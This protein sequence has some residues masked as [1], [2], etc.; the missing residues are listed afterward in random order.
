MRIH[1]QLDDS[2]ARLPLTIRSADSVWDRAADLRSAPGVHLVELTTQHMMNTGATL[3]D[4]LAHYFN[5]GSSSEAD[6][7]ALA[8]CYAGRE[9][10]VDLLRDLRDESSDLIALREVEALFPVSFVRDLNFML[11]LTTVGVPA[12]GYVRTFKDSEG[13]EYH[14]MVI[15]LTQARPHLE[16]YLGQ[17]S[18]SLLT[19][20]IRYGFFNHEGFLLA[21][22]DYNESMGRVPDKLP[23]RLKH[24]LLS[25]GIAWYL[26]YRHD[27]ELFDQINP[28]NEDDLGGCVE[29]WN[30]MIELAH[31]RAMSDEMV[32]DLL[33]RHESRPPDEQ[34]IDRLG[35]AAARAIAAAHGNKGLRDAITLGPDHFIT[36]FNRLGPHRLGI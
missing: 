11:A 33:R 15:N 4:E 35:Y 29:H 3:V 10:L 21:Y 14:G 20:T 16:N 36:L 31:K 5:T 1:Y 32:E 9:Q 27:F 25:R 12:F 26:S 18:L 34:C 7:Y 30:R 24:A 17:F 28:V 8:A 19:D 2:A 13:E 23:D 6:P 22:A